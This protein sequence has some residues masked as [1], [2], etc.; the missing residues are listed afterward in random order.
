MDI[1][2]KAGQAVG[3]AV[4]KSRERER[5]RLEDRLRLIDG[6]AEIA[7]RLVILRKY[8]LGYG[9]HHESEE[10]ALK[11]IA[12]AA[13][14]Q[15]TTLAEKVDSLIGIEIP[16]EGKAPSAELDTAYRAL[17]ARLAEVRRDTLAED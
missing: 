10:K 15:D 11:L 8:R 9:W 4:A 12:A 6:L 16:S 2:G 3:D 14:I 17:V 1:L 5:V 13:M 7:Q